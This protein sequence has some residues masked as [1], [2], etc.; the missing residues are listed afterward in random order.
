MIACGPDE[1]ELDDVAT[2]IGKVFKTTD[3]G[4]PSRFWVWK[5]SETGINARYISLN[6]HIYKKSSSV[7]INKAFVN[8]RF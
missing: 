5:S 1:Q 8:A 7:L 6:T 3:L 4:I 2:I